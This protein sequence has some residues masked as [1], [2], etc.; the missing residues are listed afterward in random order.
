MTGS[1]RLRPQRTRWEN[2][3]RCRSTPPLPARPSVAWVIWKSCR[4][5]LQTKYVFVCKRKRHDFQITQATEGLAGKGGVDLHRVGFS[6][7]VRCGRSR[8]DP[9][10]TVCDCYI[11]EEV[12]V[13]HNVSPVTGNLNF[14]F[15]SA[16][17]FGTKTHLPEQ[18][19]HR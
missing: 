11:L 17:R 2:P 14:H 16:G 10:I 18:F 19:C 1:L 8:N 4:L 15:V 13:V 12:P 6:H 7:R 5:R 9:V 3:T